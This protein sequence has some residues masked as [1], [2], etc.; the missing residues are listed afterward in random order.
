MRR[1]PVR[2]ARCCLSSLRPSSGLRYRTDWI[3]DSAPAA[4]SSRQTCSARWLG[5]WISYPSSPTNPIRNT[6]A[7]T[8][9]TVSCDAARYGTA[10][11]DRSSVAHR[12]QHLPAHRPRQV[13]RRR[14][15]TDIRQPN[16]PV[17]D[18]WP[19]TSETSYPLHRHYRW[20]SSRNQRSSSRRAIVPSSRMIPELRH[21]PLHISPGRPSTSRNG[22]GRRTRET[23]PRRGPATRACRES[24][25]RSGRPRLAYH[26]VF[27]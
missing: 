8:P 18:G 11:V 22:S 12:R 15:S 20:W 24:T 19:A 1:C 2:P 9:A 7:G 25:R 4:I 5:T 10:S 23:R 16:V 17:R 6:I 21:R 26:L 14:R 3:P 27:G 13:H